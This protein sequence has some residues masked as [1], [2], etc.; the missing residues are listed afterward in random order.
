MIWIPLVQRLSTFPLILAGPILRRT[1]P[2]AVTVWLALKDAQAVT[3]R[4]YA[5]DESSHLIQCF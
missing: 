5:R 3:L 1:E 2:R 4:I